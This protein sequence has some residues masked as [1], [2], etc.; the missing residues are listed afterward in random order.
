[1][2]HVCAH[3]CAGVYGQFIYI[4]NRTC[5]GVCQA[6]RL[7]CRNCVENSHYILFSNRIAVMVDLLVSRL[8]VSTQ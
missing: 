8:T 5:A 1:M 7:A 3:A 4:F 2:Y 6:I